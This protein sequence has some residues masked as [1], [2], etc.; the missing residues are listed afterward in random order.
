MTVCSVARVVIDPRSDRA[1]FRQLAD[2]LRRR[3]TS[4]EF[5]PGE[6]IPSEQDVM[7]Y[8]A[9]S[10]TTTRQAIALLRAEGLV[11]TEHGRGT[12]V[13]PRL[14]VRRLG[15]ER[16]RVDVEA[17]GA[18]QPATSF[19]RDQGIGWSDYRLDRVFTEVPASPE[20]AEL[21]ALPEG[22]PVL[23]RRFT[24]HTSDGPQQMSTSCYPLDLVAGTPVAD[25]A[26]EPWP[27]GNVAQLATLGIVVTRVRER[28]RA[29]MPMPDE[30]RSLA[31]PDGTAV[32]TITRVMYAGDRPV[33]AA[34]D[35][36]IPAD[37]VELTYDIDLT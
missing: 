13:R 20:L 12:Y 3:I 19:T 23:E 34:V 27:G 14:P 8:Y 15:A 28:V 4:G 32:L 10:R 25:P 29:R 36:V 37:R 9:V 1:V 7:Q 21:L 35:I 22:T 24:F 33:E 16:Y 26:N 5:A 31:I 6:A 11:I 18:R 30:A 17:R 2:D